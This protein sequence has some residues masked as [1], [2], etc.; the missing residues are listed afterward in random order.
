MSSPEALGGGIPRPSAATLLLFVVPLLLI[1]AVAGIAAALVLG[2]RLGP[3]REEGVR[4]VRPP[5]GTAGASPAPTTGWPLR[6]HLI[7]R[8]LFGQYVLR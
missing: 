8:I 2:L 7:F 1:H 4:V 3:R 6:R 5:I